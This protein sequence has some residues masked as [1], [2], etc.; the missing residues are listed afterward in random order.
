[1][2]TILIDVDAKLDEIGNWNDAPAHYRYIKLD[3]AEAAG[4]NGQAQGKL[5]WKEHYKLMSST[6]PELVHTQRFDRL[7]Q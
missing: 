2:D 6:I 1:V 4:Q 7:H 3:D 5:F